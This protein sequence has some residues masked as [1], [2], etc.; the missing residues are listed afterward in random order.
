MP[1]PHAPNAPAPP[2][3]RWAYYPLEA[4]GASSVREY[5]LNVLLGLT[6]LVVV[7]LLSRA[8]RRAYERETAR[9]LLSFLRDRP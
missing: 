6:C 9:R 7:A 8:R 2:G 4:V 1:R 5:A 3:T